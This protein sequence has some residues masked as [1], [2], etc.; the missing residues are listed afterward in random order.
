MAKA[1]RQEIRR[2]LLTK[3]RI[4]LA[5]MQ[6]RFTLLP[7]LAT[8]AILTWMPSLSS[9]GGCAS[10]D[11]KDDSIKPRD[12]ST[13]PAPTGHGTVTLAWKLHDLL[14]V[15][16]LCDQVGARAVEITLHAQGHADDVDA[17][18][19]SS[20]SITSKEFLPGTYNVSLQLHAGD[21][22]LAT[23]SDQIGVVILDGMS[24]SLA[25]VTFVVDAHGGLILTLAAPPTI[26]NCNSPL[27]MG[28]GIN[29]TTITLV[30]EDGGC[31]PVTF[32]HTKG[33]TVLIPY[34]V[35]CSSPP[36]AACIENDET[37]TVTGLNSGSYT[38]HIRGKVGAIECWKSDD[39]LQ[40][41]ARGAA[42]AQTIDLA[43]DSEN[44]LCR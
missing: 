26:S 11:S 41:P 21:E 9:C 43:L 3:A 1:T 32:A 31:A 33:K 44:A 24:T 18:A 6:T 12:A 27:R 10:G 39:M 25:P 22:T 35:N 34:T 4:V 14:G 30:Q 7:A 23:A 37:I 36:V 16:L 13:L 5:P 8:L 42:L 15:P 2:R 17:F 28:A 20:G 29:G 40:V 19:C 38:I